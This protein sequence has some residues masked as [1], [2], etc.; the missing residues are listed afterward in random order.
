MRPTYWYLARRVGQAF[1]VIALAYTLVFF[2]LNV[3]PGNPIESQINSPENPI[4]AED[5]EVLIAYYNLDKSAFEQFALSVQ[6]LVVHG[7]L[8]FSLTSG[9]SVEHLLFSSLPSTLKLASTALLL[10]IV[11]AFGIALIAVFA[12]AARI[13]E[14]ARAIPAAFL[15]TPS[16]IVGLLLLQFF[17][18]EL[19]LVSAI[20]D[21]GVRSVILPAIALA[22]P[23]SAPVAQVL[24]QG[25]QNA[26]GQPYVDV[27]R[28]KGLTENRIIFR[29]VLGNGSIP[30][31]T[32]VAI[33]VGELLAGSVITETV[34]SRTGIGYLTEQ[35]VRNQDTPVIQA[36]VILVSVIF[37]V[38]NLLADLAYPLIDPRISLTPDKKVVTA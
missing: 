32:I 11:F 27:L 10:A 26:S 23:V 4:S 16:F 7:D 25:L 18:F 1:V 37:V 24:I 6:R 22:I 21:E 3:L 29:H 13:R 31:I 14:A 12:K 20:R 17:A 5:A 15:S 9:K 33:T 19:G 38:A 34:F 8:G 2:V 30:T 35:A 36:V 28:S